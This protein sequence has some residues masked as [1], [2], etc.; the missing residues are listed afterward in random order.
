[1][2][3]VPAGAHIG[4]YEVTAALGHGSAGD[5]YSAID[6]RL[7]RP[8]AIKFLSA[9]I[10]DAAARSRFQQEARTASALNHPHIVT[11][12]ETGEWDGRQY[13]V[14]ELIDGGTLKRW[15]AAD[16]RT[17]R[18]IVDLMVGV[19]DALAAAHAAGILHRDIKPENILVTKNGY[20]KLADFGVAKLA[21]SGADDMTRSV[22]AHLTRQGVIVGTIAYM[23]PEQ[24][25]GKRLDARSDIFSFGIVLYE[26]FARRRPFSAPTE[27]ELLQSI[28]S[29][30]PEPLTDEVPV[31]VRMAVEKALEK[32]PA[33]R[34]QTMRD[35]V[36]DLR[37]SVRIGA[38]REATTI[39]AGPRLRWLIPVTLAAAVLAGL[40]LDRSLLRGRESSWHNPL[41]GATFTRLTDFDGV[42]TDAAIS[43][44]GNFVAF[45]SDRAGSMDVWV[46]QLGSGQFLNLTKGTLPNLLS[47]QVRS[48]GFTPDGSHVT[49]MIR[50]A[51]A[52]DV[53]TEIIPTIGGP[54]RLLLDGGIGPAWSADGNRVAFLRLEQ[55]IDM[56]YVADRDGSNRRQLF[57][58]QSGGH[59]H[60]FAWSPDG[61]A[62][63]TARATRNVQEYDLWR[64]A[65]TGGLPERITHH[66]AWVAYPVL[67]DDRTLLYSATDENGGGAW[68][69]AMDLTRHEEHRLSV[70]IE[71]YSSISISAPVPG[72]RRRMAVTLSNPTAS[73]WSVPIGNAV[74]PE[75]AATMFSVPTAQVSSPRFGPDYLLYLSSRELV[76]GLW[77]LRGE[78]AAELWNA[79]AGAILAPP[80][81]SRD[82]RQLAVAAWKQG[83]AGLYVMTADGANPQSLA[84]SLE[85]RESPSWSP[86]GKT[87][88]VT[89]YDDNGPGLFLVP[90][91]G[92][93]PSRV[94]D[95]LCYLPAWSPD[96]RYVLIA[97]YF[98]G[99]LMRV[100]GIATGGDTIALPDIQ[101]TRTGSRG[102]M[103]SPYRFLPDGKSLVMMD[104]EWRKPQFWLVSLETGARRQL[105]DLHP[106]RATRSF[107]IS[108]D[109][110]SI[111]FDRVQENSDIVLIDLP[112]R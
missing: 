58:E 71:Q 90:V 97:E 55:N 99:S 29:R 104:G 88:A 72:A 53:G 22:A 109:G 94:Y 64:V 45:L 77:K 82:G 44:D 33:D 87:L 12:F 65:A 96:G 43:P 91:A 46:T 75:S 108:P 34:Y 19:A 10:V 20:A 69:Y 37:R 39:T 31:A 63:Y 70:G 36:V 105:T 86:D 54:R 1:M 42:E 92:G 30:T 40:G 101:L 28:V 13:L 111:L 9:E 17:W 85:V 83:R 4:P 5:V 48:I 24:A 78:T 26:L 61:S 11:V 79:S 80:A 23:S 21:E 110:K 62:V 68:L 51:N 76:D 93:A 59:N 14:T 25:S 95:K 84:P 107:D 66:N 35:L 98:Q 52:G 100:K 57:P 47:T 7:N 41:D 112:R 2:G 38:H 27:L 103:S 50:H 3:S 16:T 49:L 81:V 18:Q 67:L 8:V 56:V 106:G 102:A 6:I 60:F 89:G 73:L 32:D 74:A 15:A